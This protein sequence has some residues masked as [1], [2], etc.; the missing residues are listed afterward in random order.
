MPYN[1]PPAPT[2][3]PPEMCHCCLI[4]RDVICCEILWRARGV[5]NAAGARR[6][7]TRIENGPAGAQHQNI[8]PAVVK[9][10]LQILLRFL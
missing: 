6:K 2:R 7:L 5:R 1:S 3:P 4:H 8:H 10:N 9:K